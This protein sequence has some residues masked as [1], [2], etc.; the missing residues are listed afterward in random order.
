MQEMCF[1]V[2]NFDVLKKITVIVKKFQIV[3]PFYTRR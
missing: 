1:D 2:E 3:F